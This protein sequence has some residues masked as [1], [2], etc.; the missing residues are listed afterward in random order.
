[1]TRNHL[2]IA[3][4]LVVAVA[5]S[6][7][8]IWVAR[9]AGK[10]VAVQEPAPLPISS[11]IATTPASVTTPVSTTAPV[12]SA[13]ATPTT[14]PA[15][16]IVR[17]AP[18]DK[19]SAPKT[20]YVVEQGQTDVDSCVASPAGG[21]DVTSCS[22]SAAGADVCWVTSDRI[23]MLCGT[24]PWEKKL[25]KVKSTTPIKGLT[26]VA[27]PSPWA[28]VLANG[29]KCRLR[30]GGSWGGR[31]DGFVG[32]YFCDRG[33][34]EFVLVNPYTTEPTIKKVDPLWTV[35]VGPLGDPEASF[36]PPAAVA[37]T[38]A[39]FAGTP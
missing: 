28:L 27:D 10:S 12:T 17:L 16:K 4:G 38:T 13:K 25:I 22:P 9:P 5:T 30:N 19:S 26:P 39:Y 14:K 6:V 32:A 37:V 23:S 29:T 34:K 36:P 15:T 35:R 20:G 31:A 8:V 3:F 24:Y 2:A 11:I 21:K 7:I 33:E 18:V 1:M